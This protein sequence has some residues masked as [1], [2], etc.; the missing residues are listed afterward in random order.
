MQNRSKKFTLI[1][2]LITMTIAIILIGL[3][4]QNLMKKPA[5]IRRKEAI[6]QLRVCFS[7]ARMMALATHGT[8]AIK[9]ENDGTK[10]QVDVISA[11]Q[12][13]FAKSQRM[14]EEEK[15]ESKKS[16]RIIAKPITFELP[17]GCKIEPADESIDLESSSTMFSFYS[18]GEAIGKRFMLTAGSKIFFIEVDRLTG[19]LILTEDE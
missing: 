9:L 4:G 6:G 7:D 5:G 1:E 8:S 14:L 15:K 19:K 16:Y 13:T 17:N 12:N 2:L 11:P 3:V 10:L 18:N